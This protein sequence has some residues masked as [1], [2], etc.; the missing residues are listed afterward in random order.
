[1]TLKSCSLIVVLVFI[2]MQWPGYFYSFTLTD[3]AGKTITLNNTKYTFTAIRPAK[4]EVMLRT[5]MC[6]DSSTIRLYVG[7]YH[8]LDDVHELDIMNTSTREKMVIK[9]PSSMSGGNE[10]YYRNLFA[11]SLHFKKGSYQIKLPATD[12]AWNNLKEK[13]FCPDYGGDDSYW[14]ISYLQQ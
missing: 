8:G 11:G 6:D 10:K 12:S 1:M 4:T 9:F 2:T 5:L 14:D 3:E 13:H 7:G